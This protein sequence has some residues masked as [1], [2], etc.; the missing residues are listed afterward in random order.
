MSISKKTFSDSIS[1]IGSILFLILV[2]V[3]NILPNG[4]TFNK[5]TTLWRGEYADVDW[6]KRL[7]YDMEICTRLINPNSDKDDL[8]KYNRAIEEYSK[9]ISKYPQDKKDFL[10][11][12]CKTIIDY[13]KNISIDYMSSGIL[14]F[15]G[16]LDSIHSMEYTP[17]TLQIF[18][19]LKQYPKIS[20]TLEEQRK[21]SEINIVKDSEILKNA[22]FFSKGM[23]L[24]KFQSAHMEDLNNK[25]KIMQSAYEKIF[26]EN[27]FNKMSE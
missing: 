20:Q 22:L 25:I 7:Q 2:I 12:G 10:K 16:K 23:T 17:H 4:W 3:Y 5:I 13:T 19:S 18:E 6:N 21:K 11:T 27:L 24:E 1:V 15:K 26:N 14:H 9:E 8:V